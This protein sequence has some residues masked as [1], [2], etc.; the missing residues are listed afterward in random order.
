MIIVATLLHLLSFTGVHDWGGDFAQYISQAKSLIEG[1]TAAFT[2]SN[3]FIIQSSK[4]PPGPVAYPWGF[5]L[6]LAPVYA[7]LGVNLFAFKLVVVL[8]YLGFL[9]TLYLGLR[10]RLSS[11]ALLTVIALF[12]FN[13]FLLRFNDEILSDIPFLFFSTV[14]LFMINGTVNHK[15]SA[16]EQT[17]HSSHRIP[18]WQSVV[19]GCVI[20]GAFLI[21]T[22]GF[23][24]ILTLALSLCV[25]ILVERGAFAWTISAWRSCVPYIV[26]DG[27]LY[28]VIT[29]S[30]VFVGLYLLSTSLFPGG[31]SSH[32]DHLERV[33]I[34]RLIN[35]FF[36]YLILIAEFFSPNE[37]RLAGLP[38]YLMTLPF[39]A[40]GVKKYWRA[41]IGFCV[42]FV[43][44]F[45][46]YVIWPHKQ[47]LRFF[48]PIIPIYVYFFVLGTE[49]A[50]KKIFKIHPTFLS[51]AIVA[52]FIV[53]SGYVVIQ[54]VTHDESSYDGP[55]SPAATEMFT[56]IREHS[57]ST[58]IVIFR[59]PRVMA[60][61]TGLRS[62]RFAKP[63]DYEKF[64]GMR[65]LVLDNQNLSDQLQ[66]GFIEG[67]LGAKKIELV[68]QNNQFKIY[69][70]M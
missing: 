52:L 51:K 64:E 18:I 48:L 65:Y 19:L 5:P 56:Y 41:N 22:N 42:Y 61:L 49:I 33:S 44:T 3:T 21:R 27:R 8:F 70:R 13:P 66:N 37:S 46:L 36:Y 26:R 24:L 17:R 20:F 35:H 1:S 68:F 23:L 9:L 16:T 31:Q 69:Q 40:L 4:P 15:G 50:Q 25:S 32:L 12:G 38:I 10:H 55:C 39:F 59:K 60:L 54:N 58:D 6:L 47:G 43:L 45:A 34:G 62:A 57:E 28:G 63:E 30:V 7:Y 11:K 2:E 53:A 14:A 29:V 67:Q